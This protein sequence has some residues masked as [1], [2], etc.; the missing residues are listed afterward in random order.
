MVVQKRKLLW[1]FLLAMLLCPLGVQAQPS[2]QIKIS[3]FNF[4]TVNNE[5]SGY[6]TTVTNMLINSLAPEPTLVILDRKE[7]ESFL[8]LNDLQQ[9]DNMDNVLQIGT[10]LGLDVIVVGTVEKRG[11]V[12]NIRCNVVQIDRKRSILRMKT[13]A[14]GDAGLTTEVR[15]LGDEVR[16]AIK[17]NLLKQQDGEKAALK[18]PAN[19]KKREGHQRVL[20]S[21]DPPDGSAGGYEIFRST[22]ENGPFAKIGQATKP[23]YLDEGL[24]RNTT[25]Y[26]KIRLYDQGGL[27]TGFSE[28]IA[29]QSALTPNPPVILSAESHIKSIALTWSPGPVSS[30]D[31]LKLKG[32]KLYQAKTEGGP[33]KEIANIRGADLGLGPDMP[34]EK[35]L[36][37]PCAVRG[38]A[39]GEDYYYKATAYNERGLESDFSRPV[40]G[41]AIP[42]VSGFEVRGEM[43]RETELTWNHLDVPSLRGYYLYRSTSPDGNFLKIK[44]IPPEPG[45]D[46]KI[47]HRDKEGLADKTRYYYRVTAMEEGDI[48]TSPSAVASAVT[49]GKPPTPVGLQAK[50]GLV[51][52]VELTWTAGKEEDIE[53]YNIYSSRDKQG[54]F[55]HLKKLSG[56]GTDR[57]MDES[58]GME[59]GT[60]Y[61]YIIA[62]YNKVDVESEATASVSATTKPRPVKPVGLTAE[63]GKVKSV[64]L[65]WTPNPEKDV[66][67]YQIFRGADGRD[68]QFSA[69]KKV[70][71][72]AQYEDRDLNDGQAYQYRIQAV[73]QDDLVSDFSD[74]VKAATKP[75]P[76]PPQDLSGSAQGG[77]A[78]I[79][80]KASPEKDVVSYTV[81]EKGFFKPTAIAT[82]IKRLSYMDGRPLKAGKDRVYLVTAVDKDGLESEYSRE[83]TVIGK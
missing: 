52:K 78:E 18:P 69:L 20:L 33:Y 34:L 83:I 65:R 50:S 1:L 44:K 72:Q 55:P 26:Y 4:G 76:Q 74:T 41:T 24:E 19:V 54:K 13:G 21:W 57:F 2:A 46:K 53:G 56:R 43:I 68:G 14:L 62:S 58:R 47:R 80:W 67:A 82:D 11:M 51:K 70:T 38:L 59:D 60:S 36:K 64:S 37:V 22:K 10:R 29:A 3:V 39:D 28:P 27:R 12:I 32:Y 45:S 42:A 25:Y 79:Q 66:T 23:E 8:S 15:K 5:A 31:P 9:N 6:G 16:K 77:G 61:H 71:G 17:E 40:R 81:Y 7:L 73:D 49:K 35:L 75:K 30:E 48:E 63:G